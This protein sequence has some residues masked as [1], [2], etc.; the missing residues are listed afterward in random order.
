MG[1]NQFF[2]K[3]H[4]GWAIH[5]SNWPRNTVQLFLSMFTPW[6]T[7][8][9]PENDRW[10]KDLLFNYGW[11]MV[12]IIFYVH[13]YLGKIPILI[14]IFQRGWNH[15]VD[16]VFIGVNIPFLR[17]FLCSILLLEHPGNYC[18][19]K[20]LHAL[21]LAKKKKKLLIHTDTTKWAGPYH[22]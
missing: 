16:G 10:E 8:M 14:N 20:I 11:V 6:Q 13:P 21:I 22:L 12:S 7:K 9:N 3:L 18:L 17:F 4:G 5:A 15:Q 2:R 19:M 1:L